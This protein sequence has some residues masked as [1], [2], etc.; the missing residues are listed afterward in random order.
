MK[1]I[2]AVGFLFLLAG[3]VHGDV[4]EKVMDA[5]KEHMDTCTKELQ[6]TPEEMEVLIK[7]EDLDD[8][9]KTKSGCYNACV[10]KHLNLLEDGVLKPENIQSITENIYNHAPEKVPQK[11]EA[12][13]QC[14]EKVK[15]ITDECE[16]AY[17]F[18]QCMKG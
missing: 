13:T 12:M 7:N 5:I 6:I 14:S 1:T 18:T 10:L 9:M 11:I 16:L 15:S 4:D 2:L 17:E 8:E 3:M